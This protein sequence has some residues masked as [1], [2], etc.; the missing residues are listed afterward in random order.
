[1]NRHKKLITH[2]HSNVIYSIANRA[3]TI[4]E[5]YLVS[6]I[7]VPDSV[8]GLKIAVEV[9]TM[10]GAKKISIANNTSKNVSVIAGKEINSY[11]KGIDTD[12]VIVK[13]SHK[14]G[15]Y[16]ATP[17][18]VYDLRGE[19]GDVPFVLVSHRAVVKSYSELFNQFK[20]SNNSPFGDISFFE[21]AKKFVHEEMKDGKVDYSDC[22]SAMVL[23]HTA[24]LFVLP[25]NF[26]KILITSA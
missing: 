11:T 18:L 20:V 17:R 3:L 5:R 26:E 6:Y 23:A 1:M 21:F 15:T 2:S 24:H 16:P 7:V 8:I 14:L 10:F 12:F 13:D 25:Y 9:G 19:C 4:V 22:N